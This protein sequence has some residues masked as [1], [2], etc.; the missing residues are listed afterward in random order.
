[1]SLSF[2]VLWIRTP[3][4]PFGPWRVPVLLSFMH[5]APCAIAAPRPEGAIALLSAGATGFLS[6]SYIHDA[7]SC[8]PTAQCGGVGR[9]TSRRPTGRRT[10]NVQRPASNRWTNQRSFLAV[11]QSQSQSG[12]FA[13]ITLALP[14]RVPRFPALVTRV[15]QIGRVPGRVVPLLSTPS[16]QSRARCTAFHFHLQCPLPP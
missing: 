12:D 4:F 7:R 10:S 16:P 9:P 5:R 13:P 2:F 6:S 1:M 15:L 3:H 11:T 14:L 8:H